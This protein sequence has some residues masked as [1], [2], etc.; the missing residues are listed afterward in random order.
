MCCQDQIEQVKNY[1]GG[2]EEKGSRW[3]GREAEVE[4]LRGEDHG[5]PKM[6]RTRIWLADSMTGSSHC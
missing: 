5:K 1:E 2:L 6:Y 3:T 4:E